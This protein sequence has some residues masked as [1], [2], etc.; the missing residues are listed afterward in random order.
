MRKRQL[1]SEKEKVSEQE[2]ERA[3]EQ[4]SKKERER[5]SEQVSKK[6]RESERASEQGREKVIMRE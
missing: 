4:V 2:G 3:S 6:E 5:V 1:V